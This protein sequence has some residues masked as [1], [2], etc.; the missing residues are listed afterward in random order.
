[1]RKVMIL[2]CVAAVLLVTT[3]GATAQSNDPLIPGLASFVLPGLGQLLNDQMDRAIVHFG[4]DVAIWTL[5]F[6]GSIYLPP[7]A[8]ATPA[9]GLGWHIYS[10]LDAY[11]VAKDQGF[12]LG[13]VENGIGFRVSF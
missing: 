13:F 7:L 6:Y 5:G 9:L 3:F 8:Y 1:M 10:A 12:Q 4:V 2:A 11:N